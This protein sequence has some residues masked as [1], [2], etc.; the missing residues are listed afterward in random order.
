MGADFHA[1][2]I[3]TGILGLDGRHIPAGPGIIAEVADVDFTPG[4]AVATVLVQRKRVTLGSTPSSLGVLVE[5]NVLGLTGVDLDGQNS[6]AVPASELEIRADLVPEGNSPGI[7]LAALDADD[8]LVLAGLALGDLDDVFAVWAAKVT[9]VVDVRLAVVWG[10]SSEALA[11]VHVTVLVSMPLLAGS[12]CGHGRATAGGR[13]SGG[14][15]NRR[16]RGGNCSGSGAGGGGSADAG[17][18]I[19]PGLPDAVKVGI[20]YI[21]DRALLLVLQVVV[22][23]TALVAVHTGD[24]GTGRQRGEQEQRVLE[25]HGGKTALDVHR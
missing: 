6:I 1:L 16:S 13:D 20:D 23:M 15:G 7:L 3:E 5:S 9:D 17:P 10:L 18:L 4:A 25:L 2:D 21:T 8:I 22:S 19:D 14:S 12:R 24:G 11:S